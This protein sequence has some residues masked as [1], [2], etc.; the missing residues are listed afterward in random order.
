MTNWERDNYR[1]QQ[2]DTAAL[3]TQQRHEIE[4]L[5]QE[6][7]RLAVTLLLFG[8]AGTIEF[9]TIVLLIWMVRR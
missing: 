4:R 7:A 3:V 8:L 5:R 1:R 9:M 6:N 2:A